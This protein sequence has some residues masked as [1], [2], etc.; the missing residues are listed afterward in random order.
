M[1][2]TRRLH[3]KGVLLQ[4]SGILKGRDFTGWNIWKGREICHFGLYKGPKELT[5]DGVLTVMAYTRRLHPKG[6]LLQASGILKGR[7]FT[8]WNIWKGREICHCGLYKGP[9][10]LTDAFWGCERVNK[11][12]WCCDLFILKRQCIYQL[13]GMQSSNL[14]MWKGYHL[15]IEGTLLW[16]INDARWQREENLRYTKLARIFQKLSLHTSN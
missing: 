8:G 12:F 1:A 6:V 2:Y 10:E 4:A 5:E 7:D 3:P 14:E 15:S 16:E 11:A 9:K 13:Q